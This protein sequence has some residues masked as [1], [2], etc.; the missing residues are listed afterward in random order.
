M[1]K[2]VLKQ[3]WLEKEALR[4]KK[5]NKNKRTAYNIQNK[6]KGNTAN[7]ITTKTNQSWQINRPHI[8]RDVDLVK[9]L[10]IVQEK[11]PHPVVLLSRVF[12]LGIKQRFIA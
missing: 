8:Y 5:Q 9:S 6:E 2:D 7:A 4:I 11:I 3:P 1:Q 12:S 10:R